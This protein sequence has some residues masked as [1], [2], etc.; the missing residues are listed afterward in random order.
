LRAPR[1]KA[2]APAAT[3]QRPTTATTANTPLIPAAANAKAKRP[4]AN[5]KIPKTSRSSGSNVQRFIR[6]DVANLGGASDA[7]AG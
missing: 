5:V 3:T 1:I 4:E 7:I 6:S 2:H